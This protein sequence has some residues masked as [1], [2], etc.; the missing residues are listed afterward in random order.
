MFHVEQVSREEWFM[1]IGYV[2]VMHPRSVQD[3]VWSLIR[4]IAMVLYEELRFILILAMWAYDYYAA[5][6]IYNKKCFT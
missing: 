5:Y 2:H 6:S 1:Y 3:K 4:E